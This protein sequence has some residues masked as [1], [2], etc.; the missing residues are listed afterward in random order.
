[1]DV[2]LSQNLFVIPF[3]GLCNDVFVFPT[4]PQ[5]SYS[6]YDL[7]IKKIIVEHYFWDEP[8][9]QYLKLNSEN[10]TR[11]GSA[12]DGMMGSYPSGKEFSIK[13]NGVILFDRV[14]FA[15]N[16]KLEYLNILVKNASEIS[17]KMFYPN[18]TGY[19][20]YFDMFLICE[21]SKPMFK[22]YDN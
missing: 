17:V 16:L 10:V 12:V 13:A 2:I 21:R 6:G 19:S 5:G 20:F 18:L 7:N 14:P 22:K 15:P 11:Y 4:I 9:L 1:M 3:S 8:N